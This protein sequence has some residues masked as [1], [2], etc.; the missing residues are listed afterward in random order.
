ME[1]LFVIVMGAILSSAVAGIVVQARRT[2]AV[3]EVRASEILGLQRAVAALE[4]DLREA[5]AFETTPSGEVLVHS[6][7]GT[8]SYRLA[9]GTLW[10]AA[11]GRRVRLAV[12]VALFRVAEE[13]GLRRITLDLLRPGNPSRRGAGVT[14]VVAPRAGEGP[15]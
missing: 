8:V 4:R 1:V 9:G 7:R 5:A 11:E 3:A 15:R 2:N 10:R 12:N 13:G 14:A 6:P